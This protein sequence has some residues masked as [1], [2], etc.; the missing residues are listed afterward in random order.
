M[1][2]EFVAAEAESSIPLVKEEVKEK[3]LHF[4]Y[5]ANEGEEEGQNLTENLTDQILGAE[6]RQVNKKRVKL[7][8]DHSDQD[9]GV[10]PLQ[11]VDYSKAQ[12][13]V[14]ELMEP[15]HQLDQ[16]EIKASEG[17]QKQEVVELTTT[18]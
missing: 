8:Y 6:G 7:K 15:L 13:N 14:S 10:S 9:W 3:P 2:S 4:K 12:I 16:D 1:F 11:P 18:E 5:Y 17:S